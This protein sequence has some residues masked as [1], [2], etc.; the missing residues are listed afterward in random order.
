MT[1]VLKWFGIVALVV[2]LTFI[3]ANWNSW[4]DGVLY[5]QDMFAYTETPAQPLN[6]NGRFGFCKQFVTLRNAQRAQ[7]I[8]NYLDARGIKIQRLPIY[9]TKFDNLFVPFSRLKNRVR[10]CERS[11][12]SWEILTSIKNYRAAHGSS[13]TQTIRLCIPRSAW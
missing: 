4:D 2:L 8:E 12:T 9:D 1:R 5:L 3:I 6:G 13:Y 10:Q 11:E 7:F